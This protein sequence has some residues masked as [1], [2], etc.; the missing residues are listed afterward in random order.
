MAGELLKLTSQSIY[1]PD[2]MN[3]TNQT[4]STLFYGASA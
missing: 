4:E 1:T 3:R 2:G